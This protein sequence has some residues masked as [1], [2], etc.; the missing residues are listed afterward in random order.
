MHEKMY[1]VN[2]MVK[3]HNQNV[4][5]EWFWGFNSY[6]IIALIKA[7]ETHQPGVGDLF[8]IL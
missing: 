3:G 4:E 8:N 7:G 2:S 1:Y 5:R 6:Y